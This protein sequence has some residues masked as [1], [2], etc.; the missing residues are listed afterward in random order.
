MLWESGSGCAWWERGHASA[1]CRSGQKNEYP[2]MITA[3]SHD[4]TNV[5][6][7]T[8]IRFFHQGHPPLFRCSGCNAAWRPL[9]PLGTTAVGIRAHPVTGTHNMHVRVVSLCQYCRNKY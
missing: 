7:F 4:P 9:A 3:C 8:S 2:F 1:C 5:L 6:L